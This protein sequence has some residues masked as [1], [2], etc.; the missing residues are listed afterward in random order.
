MNMYKIM[1]KQKHTFFTSAEDVLAFCKEIEVK[2]NKHGLYYLT[3]DGSFKASFPR[4]EAE[5]AILFYG[6]QLVQQRLSKTK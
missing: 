2:Q 4:E 5:D 6:N 1:Q 3:I